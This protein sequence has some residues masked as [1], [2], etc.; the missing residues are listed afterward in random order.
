MDGRAQ[1]PA[2]TREIPFFV[3]ILGIGVAAMLL[4]AIHAWSRTDYVTASAFFFTSVIGLVVTGLL[5]LATQGRKPAKP[6]RAQLLT[7]LGAFVLLP[8]IFAIPVY[9]VVWRISFLEAWFE[10]VSSFTTTGAT[11]YD[12]VT[13]L[14]PSIHLWRATVGWLGGLLVWITAVALLAPM[15]IG[16]FEVRAAVEGRGQTFVQL[17]R[18]VDATVRL[19]RAAV[20]LFPIYFGLTGT[21][22]ILLLLAG[23]VPLVALCHAMSVL[24]TSGISPVGGV[25]N[26]AS[27]L[28]GEVLIFC[29]LIFAVSRLTYSRGPL[30]DKGREL[31]HDPEIRIAAALVVIVPT[32]LMLRHFVGAVESEDGTNLTAAL[33]ALW[34]AVFTVLSFLTT[35]GFESAGWVEAQDWSGL[36]TPGLI[37]VGLALIGGGV[38]TTAGGVKLLRVY[39]L[40]KHG[41]RELERLV[42]PSSIGGA[43]AE[44]RQIRRQ[45]AYISWIFFMLFALSIAAVML[46][47]TLTG[48]QFETA[49]VLAVAA[50]ST[51]GPL[52]EIAAE[53]PILYAGIPDSAKVVLAFAMVL[54]RL[55]TLAII[56]LFN[57]DFWR[58]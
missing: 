4:P 47:L 13:R 54:G 19:Q 34:S 26:A 15:N 11:L 1:A 14:N 48:V 12:S 5:A 44:A 56:A 22:W 3:I 55:E 42:H 39:A 20:Q 30:G 9:E 57:P 27:G 2:G 37:L 52:A 28:V 10:M 29:F 8:V 23:E 6:A 25:Q 18:S 50:L 43:G 24:A 16:G 40:F 21:L 51:T 35:T 33:S 58:N 32:L 49:M 53:T 36:E 46:L 7:L 41:E 38:A 31:V 17:G 45:G